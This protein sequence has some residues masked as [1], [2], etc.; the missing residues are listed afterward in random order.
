MLAFIILLKSQPVGKSTIFE[1]DVA[2]VGLFSLCYLF[3]ALAIT[4]HLWWLGNLI[5][6]FQS[7]SRRINLI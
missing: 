3:P 6:S 4:F 1:P 5:L 2:I 7:N